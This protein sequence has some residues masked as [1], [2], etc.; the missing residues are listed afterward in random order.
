MNARQLLMSPYISADSKVFWFN[1]NYSL[2][3]QSCTLFLDSQPFNAHL[4][5]GESLF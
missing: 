3:F 5:V 1:T 4:L 2:V